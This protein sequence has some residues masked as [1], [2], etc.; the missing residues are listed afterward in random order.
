ML[1]AIWQCYSDWTK[2]SELGGT[3]IYLLVG[4]KYVR[5]T[6][7]TRPRQDLDVDGNVLWRL[8]NIYMHSVTFLARFRPLTIYEDD[9]INNNIANLSSGKESGLGVPLPVTYAR[10]YAY[11]N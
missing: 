7:G 9:N 3:R 6:L 4:D 11:V 1:T 5:K 2:K 8:K 10:R